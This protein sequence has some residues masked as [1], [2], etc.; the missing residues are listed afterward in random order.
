MGF[1]T[2]SILA[3]LAGVALPVQ[4]AFN[5]MVAKGST[6]LWASAISFTIGTVGMFLVVLVTRQ[7]MPTVSLLASVPKY[8]WISGLIGAFYVTTSIFVAPKI[9]ALYFSAFVIVGQ[10]LVSI[11][12][13]HYGFAGFQQQSISWGRIA[14]AALLLAGLILIRKF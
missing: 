14:G 13:D 7:P 4:I 1:L 8:V 12:I 11:L 5:H 9:G 2:Y 6:P 3:L 10:L